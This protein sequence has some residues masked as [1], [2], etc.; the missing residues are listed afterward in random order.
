MRGRGQRY[1]V[2]VIVVGVAVGL[3]EKRENGRL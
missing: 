2:V 3:V 1:D